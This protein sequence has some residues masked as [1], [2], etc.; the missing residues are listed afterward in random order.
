MTQQHKKSHLQWCKKLYKCW[1]SDDWKK[2]FFSDESRVFLGTGDDPGIFVWRRA[3]EKFKED[4]LKIEAKY[5]H[6][7][8]VWS[9][10]TSVRVGKL[11]I[12]LRTINSQVY[13][14]ILEHCLIPRIE[15]AFG[16][17]FNFLF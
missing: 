16:D 10:M 5:Q 14:D 3:D 7:F 9:C 8:I 12:V 13:V 4:C 6:S 15:K 1:S 17:S 2:V 11:C